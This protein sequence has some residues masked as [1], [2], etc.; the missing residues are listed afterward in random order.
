MRSPLRLLN[1]PR[2]RLWQLNLH[3]RHPTDRRYAG[4]VADK[5]Q[6]PHQSRSTRMGKSKSATAR[7]DAEIDSAAA[8]HAFEAT[9]ELYMWRVR[10][11]L[12]P[13]IEAR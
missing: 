12:T 8:G 10:M 3:V 6:L 13:R 7:D 4:S 1:A 2:A 9:V 11:A 5:H